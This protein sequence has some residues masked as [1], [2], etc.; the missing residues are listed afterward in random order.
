[1]VQEI[2]II[3]DTTKTIDKIKEIF[4]EEENEYKFSNIKI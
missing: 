1:M 3:D 4:K 2:Y